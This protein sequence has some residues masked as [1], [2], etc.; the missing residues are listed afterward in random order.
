[1]STVTIDTAETT[2]RI[3]TT[4]TQG[5]S[6]PQG[7]QGPVGVFDES[8][9]VDIQSQ[10]D[11]LESEVGQVKTLAQTNDLKIGTKADQ[12][13]LENTQVQVEQNRLSLLTKADI[14]ALALLTQLV[15]TKAD[16]AYVNQQIANLVGYAPAALDTVYELAAAIQNEQGLIDSL[17]QSVA[18]RVRFDIATQALTEIQ[19]QNARTNIDAEK[20][21]T[22]QQLISQI[23]AQSIGA[24]T[25]A[26]GLKANTALQSADV[27]P[28]ALSGLFSSLVGQNGIFNVVFNAYTLGSNTA[29]VATDT[30]GQMLGKLQAQISANSAVTWVD[31]T[32][33]SGFT[34]SSSVDLAQSKIELAKINGLIW[35]RGY[36]KFRG[37]HAA[38]DTI[39][40]LSSAQW[41][42]NS[43]YRYSPYASKSADVKL[44]GSR[45][46][47][48]PFYYSELAGCLILNAP[49][50]DIPITTKYLIQS[51]PLG[52][53]AP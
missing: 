35:I 32:T 27:A 10:V 15:D 16:Q 21:G 2:I 38:N 34:P 24:A 23:T 18:N 4:G 43:N 30:L 53:T 37:T 9:I 12:V 44:F 42:T 3:L 6:G 29:I 39:F 48:C 22:A 47:L 26:Q 31:A 5:P 8:V 11:N 1:M 20:T 33:I 25:A 19:K 45:E 50:S 14:Q 52:V 13:A 49:N 28:V 41:L 46:F 51:V 40:S 17:N 36:I 7:P